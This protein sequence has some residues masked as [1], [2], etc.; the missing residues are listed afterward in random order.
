MKKGFVHLVPLLLVAVVAFGA[1]GGLLYL[2]EQKKKQTVAQ[3]LGERGDGKDKS[4]SSDSDNDKEK[5]SA[6]T[7]KVESQD[8]DGRTKIETSPDKQSFSSNK[9]KVEMRGQGGRFETKVEEGKE[10]TKIRTGGLRIEIKREDDQVVT[11]IKNEQD[12]E[13]EVEDED[14]DE[15]LEEAQDLLKEKGLRIATGEAQL[16]FIQDGRR[17]RTNFPLSVN[18]QT[19]Q[20]MVSTPAGDRVVTVLPNQAIQNMIAAGILTRVV[21]ETPPAPEGAAGA[22]VSGSGVVLS[23]T[24]GNPVY[25]ISGVR[26]QNFLGLVPVEI[27]IKT[28]VSAVNGKLLDVEQG[29]FSRILDLFS[30]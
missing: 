20:L 29:L 21:D 5:S 1:L 26:N 13:V 8:G 9:T 18:A 12:E 7:V 4:K 25:V 6:D 23:E 10:E 17:V 30:F 27:K 16:G 22:T 2:S 15:L 14:V 19:G 28:V 11:K 3:V 24:G